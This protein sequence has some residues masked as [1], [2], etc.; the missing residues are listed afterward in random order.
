MSTTPRTDAAQK[1]AR[2]LL[3]NFQLNFTDP[4]NRQIGED[5]LAAIIRE[6]VMDLTLDLDGTR[7]A[8]SEWQRVAA[9]HKAELEATQKQC[10]AMR[11]AL[12]KADTEL[13]YW[14]EHAR[15]DGEGQDSPRMPVAARATLAALKRIRATLTTNAGKGFVRREVLEQCRDALELHDFND[16]TD[17]HIEAQCSDAAKQTRRAFKAATAELNQ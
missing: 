6:Q 5:E 11:E 3:N 16:L 4:H 9:C 15:E 1:T 8:C 7:Q 12:E 2:F 14:L 13:Q 10:A 17:E